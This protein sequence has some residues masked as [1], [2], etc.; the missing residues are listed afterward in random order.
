MIIALDNIKFMSFDIH[1]FVGLIILFVLLILSGLISGSEA[2]F[3]A[4]SP[5]D[6]DRLK[7]KDNKK[8]AATITLLKQPE[9]LLGSILIANNF[10]NIG[11]V[12]LSSKITSSLIDFSNAPTIGFVFQTIIITFLILLFGEIIPKVL[13]TKQPYAFSLRMTSTFTILNKIFKPLNT[14][15]IKSTSIVN[16]KVGHHK[17]NM[18]VSDLSHALSLTE[19]HE[20]QE[21]KEILEGIVKFGKK[22]VVEI[23]CSR[24]DTIALDCN[25]SFT[26]VIQ[27]INNSGYSRIP[28]FEDTF[29]NIRGVLYIKDLLAHLHKGNTF[30]W[31]TLIRPPF[32]IPENKKIDDLLEE[33]QKTKIHMAFVIDE[34]GG[35]SGIVTLEDVLEEIVGEI[36]DEFD[37]DEKNYT[38]VDNDTYIFDA[39]TLLVDFL[40]DLH[41]DEEYLDDVKG[42]ADTI[43]GL[44]LEIKGDFPLVKEKIQIRNID[45]IVEKMDSRRIIEIRVIFK[46]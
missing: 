42:D 13:A 44:L 16:K 2:S 32:Y 12:L 22:S 11:I 41:L 4:L 14:V 20:I 31:Q 8:G 10:I 35:V 7:S 23:M 43:A 37:E 29:D 28:I 9:Q 39:K 17:N 5:H 18:S 25:E 30:R 45:F 33:F 26:T 6:I 34:Y 38:K 3:F 24:L 40:R 1:D 27:T 19:E 36:S 46:S 15:L 21:D